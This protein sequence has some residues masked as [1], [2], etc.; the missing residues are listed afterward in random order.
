[1]AYNQLFIS[2]DSG[3]DFSGA[4]SVTPTVSKGYSVSLSI[5]QV[6]TTT[7][8]NYF[9]LGTHPS[10]VNDAQLLLDKLTLSLL[11]SQRESAFNPTLGSFITKLKT[12]SGDLLTLQAQIVGA[13]KVIQNAILAAQSS[14]TLSDSQTLKQ[15]KLQD[16]YQNGNDPTSVLVDILVVTNANS[17]YILT[18]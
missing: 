1:M 9:S 17:S 8:Q 13:L 12:T 11:T 10:T 18:V 14:Q 3:L 5:T 7:G 6:D 4:I 16:V 15:L 2:T